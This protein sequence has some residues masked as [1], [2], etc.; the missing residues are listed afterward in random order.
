MIAYSAVSAPMY[1]MPS[2]ASAADETMGRVAL[3]CHLP[4][5]CSRG[6]MYSHLDVP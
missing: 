3:S 1:T 6:R 2:G 4:L 5:R